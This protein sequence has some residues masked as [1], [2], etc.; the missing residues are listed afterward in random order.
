MLSEGRLLNLGNATGHPSF[1]MSA[2]FSNQTIA[3]IEIHKNPDD[4]IVDGKPTVTT[5]PK[6]LD[7]KV[8]RLHLDAVGAKLTDAHQGAGRVHRRRRR[9]PVQAGALPLLGA[10]LSAGSTAAQ[11]VVALGAQALSPRLTLSG[12]ASASGRRSSGS[13]GP[14]VQR[15]ASLDPR[16]P[17]SVLTREDATM[18]A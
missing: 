5:L 6:H 9:R 10:A 4:Y 2:S 1:V 12:L 7:E 18:E 16:D 14:R 11:I 17:A 15:P 3:Q 13:T 8:A